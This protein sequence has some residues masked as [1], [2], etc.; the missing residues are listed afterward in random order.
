MRRCGRVVR[1]CVGVYVCVYVREL[2][3]NGG[4]FLQFVV[5]LG[6]FFGEGDVEVNVRGYIKQAYLVEI[7]GC[8]QGSEE[9]YY[10]QLRL[11]EKGEEIRNRIVCV[12]KWEVV[13]YSIM[14]K[15]AGVRS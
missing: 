3:E 1:E 12:G 14:G 4:V 10:R 2:W 8:G 7:E 15:V 13:C 11:Y 5:Y 9:G 6:R